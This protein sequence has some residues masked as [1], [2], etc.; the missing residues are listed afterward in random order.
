MSFPFLYPLSLSHTLSMCSAVQCGVVCSLGDRVYQ[1]HCVTTFREKLS[2]LSGQ[3]DKIIHEANTE[4]ARLREKVAGLE[5][6]EDEL[7]RKNHELMENW[8]E[9]GRKLAQTQVCG[10]E[11]SRYHKSA[12]ILCN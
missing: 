2:T 8:R 6:A 10:R 12:H 4:I 1:E 5:T 3:L 7:K 9:K 11:K